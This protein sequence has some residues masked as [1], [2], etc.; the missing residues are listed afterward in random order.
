VHPGDSITDDEN[1]HNDF[2]FAQLG[3]RV[4]TV[5]ISPRIPRNLIDHRVYDHSSVI[6]TVGELFGFGAL[7]ARDGAANSLTHLLSLS[8]PRTDA[9]TQLPP[10]A[11]SGLRCTRDAPD[12]DVGSATGGLVGRAEFDEF[13][14]AAERRRKELKARP[15]E[16]AVRGFVRV[17]LRRYLSVAPIAERDT[18][19]ER[20]LKLDN[21][22]DARLFIKEA[23]DVIKAHKL[24]HPPRKPW[25]RPPRKDEPG[26]R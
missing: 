23:A 12:A 20:F 16:P 3:V 26:P 19:V 6:R 22:Y 4:P 1:N 14:G 17:A 15:I 11:D 7:T 21:S 5:V 2:D 9:P 10:V 8:E 18:I 25:K 24:L 13:S